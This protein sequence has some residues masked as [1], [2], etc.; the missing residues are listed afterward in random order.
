MTYATYESKSVWIKYDFGNDLARKW[1]GDD[2]VDALPKI[3]RGKNKGKP[4]GV[5]CWTKCHRGG[6]VRAVPVGY[7]LRPGIHRKTIT[8]DGEP[9]FIDPH[10]LPKDR[11]GNMATGWVNGSTI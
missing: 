1:F 10:D 6:W 11:D 2:V 5:L 9:I 7:V 8:L 3:T 4:K